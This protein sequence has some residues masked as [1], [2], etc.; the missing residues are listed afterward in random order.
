MLFLL[1]SLACHT[2]SQQQHTNSTEKQESNSTNNNS[3]EKKEHNSTNNKSVDCSKLKAV[4]QQHKGFPYVWGGESKEEGGFDCSGFIYS[5]A[6]KYGKPLPRTTSKKYWLAIDSDPVTWKNASC[7]YFIWWTLTPDR[8]Y[9]H[10]GVH[11]KH[12]NIWQSGSST[13]PTK[14]K[15]F[16]GSYWDTH[17]KGS[18]TYF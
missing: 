3:T 12:P 9:G 5:V 16:E 8:P 15:L 2:S 1:F 17:S 11:V 18:K 7:G 13:G 14:E 10:I 4:C 6:K